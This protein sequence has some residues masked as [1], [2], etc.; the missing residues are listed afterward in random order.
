MYTQIDQID[1]N[2]LLADLTA[3]NMVW[4][5]LYVYFKRWNMMAFIMSK[6]IALYSSNFD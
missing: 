5:F 4:Q 2:L 3:V 6:R 1:Y